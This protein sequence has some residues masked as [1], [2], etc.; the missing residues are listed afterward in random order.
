[1]EK[2]GLEVSAQF[3]DVVLQLLASYDVESG[4]IVP[5]RDKLSL[6]INF[7]HEHAKPPVYYNVWSNEIPTYFPDMPADTAF[8][9]IYGFGQNIKNAP[10]GWTLTTFSN[11]DGSDYMS[12]YASYITADTDSSGAR[13]YRGHWAQKDKITPHAYDPDDGWASKIFREGYTY[14]W[15]AAFEK[16]ET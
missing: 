7:A 9:V 15:F 13:S 10:K 12:K 2:I 4:T 16:E 3:D 6:T 14:K 1:M 5:D 11:D 8:Q